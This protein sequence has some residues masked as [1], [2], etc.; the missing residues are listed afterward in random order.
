METVVPSVNFVLL[1]VYEMSSNPYKASFPPN[2]PFAPR[3][4]TAAYSDSQNKV[5][6]LIHQVNFGFDLVIELLVKLCN[7]AGIDHGV[8]EDI[9]EEKVE[10]EIDFEEE[11]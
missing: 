10:R 5:D 6:E 9:E 8:L 3:K 11:M 2:T 7:E 4:R 1:C